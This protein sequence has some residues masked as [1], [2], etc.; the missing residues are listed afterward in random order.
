MILLIGSYRNQEFIRIGYYVNNEYS[1]TELNS[2]PPEKPIIEKLTRNILKDKPRV[3]K[4]PIL[5]DSS[6]CYE[7]I[8]PMPKN[9]ILEEDSLHEEYNK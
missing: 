2:L 7:N 3:T 1:E 5:W 8:E 6:R 9:N 4:V